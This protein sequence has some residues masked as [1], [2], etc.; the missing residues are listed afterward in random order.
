VLPRT[1]GRSHWE[2]D[3]GPVVNGV[4]D[5]TAPPNLARGATPVAAMR[6]LAA[7]LRKVGR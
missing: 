6:A 4:W 1:G 3:A 7:K 2:A 5:L